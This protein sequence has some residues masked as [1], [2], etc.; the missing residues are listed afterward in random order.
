MRG[1]FAG[2]T[3]S[4]ILFRM[5]MNIVIEYVTATA[6]QPYKIGKSHLSPARAFIDDLNLSCSL[7]GD[8]KSPLSRCSSVLKWADKQFRPD[9][10]RS[11]VMVKGRCVH[12]S[13]FTGSENKAI[14][15]IHY[16]IPMSFA[17]KLENKVRKWLKLHH[18]TSNLRFDS[19]HSPCHLQL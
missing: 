13:P 1:I 10:S 18:T 2:C 17:H 14:P 11:V 4:V 16:E 15:P 5:G 8:V 12:S 9:K 7:V 19:S 6:V 3:L